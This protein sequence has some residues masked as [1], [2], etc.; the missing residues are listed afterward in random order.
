MLCFVLADT[1]AHSPTSSPRPS[2]GGSTFCQ[3]LRDS[4]AQSRRARGTGVLTGFECFWPVTI[5]GCAL[6]A[7]FFIAS[8]DG[9]GVGSRGEWK[10]ALTMVISGR[11]GRGLCLGGHAVLHSIGY[12][13]GE[14]QTVLKHGK[15][16]Q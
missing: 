10:T 13:G 2:T 4:A 3:K 11:W 9:T 15:A 6:I 16:A 7:T 1:S 14:P 12:L 5:A 8:C